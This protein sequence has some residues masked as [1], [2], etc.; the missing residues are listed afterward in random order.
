MNRYAYADGS[1]NVYAIGSADTRTIE[2]KPVKPATSSSGTYD[3]GEPFSKVL[4]EERYRSLVDALETAVAAKEQH[5]AK[6][7]MMS[8]MIKVSDGQQEK[9]YFLAARS[10]AMITIERS[11]KTATGDERK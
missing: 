11:I 5:I 4:P 7:E 9:T 8:G 3:G 1:G 6:R 10:P 2:Y